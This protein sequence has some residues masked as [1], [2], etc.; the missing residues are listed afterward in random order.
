MKA[1]VNLKLYSTYV[2]VIYQSCRPFH[3]GHSWCDNVQ[4][5]K[6]LVIIPL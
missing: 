4:Y 1:R 2:Y 3:Y 6:V 5:T